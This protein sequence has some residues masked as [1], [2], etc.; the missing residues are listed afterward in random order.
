MNFSDYGKYL[1]NQSLL[2]AIGFISLVMMQLTPQ[3]ATAQVVEET[4][5]KDDLVIN[6]SLPWG[7]KRCPYSKVVEVLDLTDN[8]Y[9][10]IVIDRYGID[11]SKS[12]LK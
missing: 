3:P 4:M 1:A 2:L 12:P 8:V 10:R 7:I 6:S 11:E 5:A 9:G